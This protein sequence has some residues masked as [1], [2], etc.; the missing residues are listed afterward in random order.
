[1]TIVSSSMPELS[2]NGE[3]KT[4]RIVAHLKHVF[5][6]QRQSI[7][8]HLL[9][10]VSFL[11][12]FLVLN[13]PQTI[14]ISQLG[15]SAW[16]PANGLVLA[17][18]LGVSPWYAL[19]VALSNVLAGALIYHQPLMSFGETLGAMGLAGWYGLAAYILRGVLRID[20]RLYRGR[21]VVRYVVI[22]T[23][24]ALGST[25]TGVACLLGDHI[26]SSARFLAHGLQLVHW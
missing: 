16:Y 19:L 18:M 9:L 22:A 15:S 23:A 20:S 17:L 1:M 13:L 26:I 4:G 24:A 2:R 14:F 6:H 11:L 25:V 12:V 7:I 21:D 10:S 3:K 5:M 8:H